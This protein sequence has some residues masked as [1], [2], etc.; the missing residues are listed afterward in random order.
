MTLSAQIWAMKKMVPAMTRHQIRLVWRTFT[1][2][3][4]PT[5]NFM[6]VTSRSV[7]GGFQVEVR[8]TQES[9]GKAAHGK[10]GHVEVLELEEAVVADRVIEVLP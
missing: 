2:K 4:E 5:P 7:K 6:L 9:S 3:S 10:N 8:T 1:K